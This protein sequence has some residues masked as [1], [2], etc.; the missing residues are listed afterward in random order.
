MRRL[1]VVNEMKKPA[2]CNNFNSEELF[3]FGINEPPLLN[4]NGLVEVSDVIPPT[5]KGGSKWP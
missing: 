4:L 5:K 3:I 2:V 1:M